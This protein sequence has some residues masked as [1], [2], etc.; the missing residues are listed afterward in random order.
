L[1]EPK[2]DG[3]TPSFADQLRAIAEQKMKEVNNAYDYFL[4]LA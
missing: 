1:R 2:S 3:G 4:Q